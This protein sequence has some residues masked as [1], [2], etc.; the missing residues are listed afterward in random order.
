MKT[1]PLK[2]L[3]MLLFPVILLSSC[4]SD[5][6]EH[7]EGGIASNMAFPNAEGCGAVGTTGARGGDAV[8]V[9]TTLS[10]E[11]DPKTGLPPTSSL[12]GVL[13]TKG[14]NKGYVIFSVSGTIKLSSPL[15]I[16][17]NTTIFGQSAPGDGICISGENMSGK[18]HL[19]D[20][21][22]DNVIVQFMRF[23]LANDAVDADAFN[24]IGR[25]RIVIDH[26]SFSWSSDECVTCYG[27]TNFTMQWCM[28]YEGLN[29]DNKGNHGFGGIWGG[30][31]ASFHHNLIANQ[32]NRY[33]RFDHDYVNAQRRGPVD[34]VNNVIYITNN[35]NG[36]YGGESGNGTS[37]PRSINVVNNYYKYSSAVTGSRRYKILEPSTSCSNCNPMIVPGKFYVYGNYADGSDDVSI[38]NSKGVTTTSVL[39]STPFSM[40]KELSKQT[41]TAAYS[42]V[43]AHAGSSFR[44]DAADTKV[45]NDVI[46]NTGTTVTGA[47]SVTFP[48]LDS[49]T[50]IKDSDRDGLPDDWEDANGL[51]KTDKR[52]SPKLSS[53]GSGYTNLEEYM[54][55]LVKDLY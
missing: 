24:C 11:L 38:D 47:S 12:R 31:N 26:C 19:V 20:I 1:S 17:S 4:R 44:R 46:N 54:Q 14:T 6:D 28:A 50:A 51:D 29:T 36:V 48:I 33:P 23:R 10:D 8:Y 32:S 41:A 13:R 45:I 34:F 39:V 49:G 25:D 18:D 5:D 55:S 35:C 43:L 53:S 30:T 42:S 37:T 21:A 52:D 9:V 22:G 40:S 27:N 15:S 2:L 3:A 16:P 7:S